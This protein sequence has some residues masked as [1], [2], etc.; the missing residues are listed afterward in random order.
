MTVPIRLSPGQIPLAASTVARRSGLIAIPVLLFAGFILLL[1]VLSIFVRTANTVMSPL[2]LA[3][4]FVGV[5]SGAYGIRM[6]IQQRRATLAAVKAKRRPHD[7]LVPRWARR[8][9]ARSRKA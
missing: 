9:S 2:E 4:P 7:V 1:C 8:D 6:L 3:L 5:F